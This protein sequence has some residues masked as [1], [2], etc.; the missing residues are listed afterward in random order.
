L[1]LYSSYVCNC[2]RQRLGTTDWS[3]LQRLSSP[4]NNAGKNE[5]PCLIGDDT[6]SVWYWSQP[7]AVCKFCLQ[8]V[9]EK[10]GAQEKEETP[11][12]NGKIK[13][14]ETLE[15]CLGTQKAMK[16]Q[17]RKKRHKSKTENSTI[18]EMKK[19]GSHQGIGRK[20]KK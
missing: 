5:I 3:Y 14:R 8:E 4:K 9:R 17:M 6:N 2:I 13:E 7:V 18:E 12:K 16:R 1:E 15:I 20:I 19:E 10:Y 11:G